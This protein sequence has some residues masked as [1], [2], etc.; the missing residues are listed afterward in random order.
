VAGLPVSTAGDYFAGRHLPSQSQP[1][2][3]TRILKACGESDAAQVDRWS[4]ALRRARRAPGPRRADAAIPYRGLASFQ[5]ED[6]AWFFGRNDLT[7]LLQDMVTGAD[8]ATVPLVV[9]GPSG[10]G[11]SSLL[12]AGLIPALCQSGLLGQ[13]S[14]N[15]RWALFT[16]GSTPV[17][18]LAAHLP[19]TAKDM[20]IA[21]ALRSAALRITELD[22]R[23]VPQLIVV[24]QFEEVF[25]ACPDEN[26][27]QAFIGA[28]AT[29]SAS[30]VVVLGLR[31]DFYGHALRYPAL[32]AALQ[33]RQ[34]VVRP[35]TKEQLT[36]AIV[37]PARLAKADVDPGLVELLLRELMPSAAKRGGSAVGHEPG[38]LPLLSHALLSTWECCR[39][40]KLTVADYQ[41]SG[42]IRGAVTRTAEAAYDALGKE[43]RDQ[44]RRLFLQLVQV[45]D[46]AA[47]TRR[48]VSVNDLLGLPDRAFGDAVANVLKGFVE[49]RLITVSEE[50]AEISHEAL[51]DAWPRLR[52]WIDE[53][54]VGLRIRRRIDDGARVWQDTGQDEAALPRGGQLAIIAEWAADLVNRASLGTLARE[55]IDA[56]SRHELAG[57]EAERRRNRRLRQLVATLAALVLVTVGLT[58]Y[59]FA[60]R[61]VASTARDNADSRELAIEASQLR[62]QDVS[63][64][65]Q[66]SL[67]AY[68]TAPTPEALAS[69]LDS[70]A[71]P[72]AARLID[73][74]DAVE[75]V[76]AS[77]DRHVLA[78]A[79]AD[80]SLRLWDIAAPGQPRALGPALIRP[81][82]SALYTA[83][84]SPDGRLLA[85]GGAGQTI[86]LW[87]V[88][89]LR[90]PVPA[91]APLSGPA[92]TVYS[93]AFTSDSRTL[94][95]GSANGTVHLWDVT[96]PS[97][98]RLL[99]KLAVPGGD[100]QT[101]AFSPDA[102]TL[103][104]GSTNGTVSLWD[105]T[106]PAHP[107]PLGK[108]LT[109]PSGAVMSIAFSPDSRTLAA[110]SRDDRV[111]L[112]NIASRADPDRL[113]PLSGATDWVNS[114][115]FSPA[116]ADLA[117]GSSDGTV[118]IWD[119]ATRSPLTVLPHPGIVTSLTWDD[120]HL[121]LTGDAD[122]VVRLWALPSP[123]L[124]ADGG[125]NAAGGG[126][127][128]VAFSPDGT[129]LAAGSQDLELWNTASRTR[130]SAV[131]VLGSWVNAVGFGQRDVLA[132]GY[133]NGTVQ[134]WRVAHGD[135]QPFGH[136]L[137]AT[138]T[139]VAVSNAMD[140]VESLAFSHDGQMLAT[141][142]DDG[143]VRL[144]DVRD[145][146]R[147]VLLAKLHDSRSW[148]LGVAFS[149]V[150][151]VLAAA[152]ADHL[153][154]LWNISKPAKPVRL[155][156]PLAGP[157]NA[158][159]SVA[160]SPDGQILAVGSADQAVRLWNVTRPAAPAL[161][162]RP[163]TGLGGY[164]YSVAFS[165]DGQ[166]LAAGI[167]DGTA[168]MWNITSP[169]HPALTA[170]LNG[171]GEA[172]FTV[173]FNPDGQT[174]AAGSKDNTIRL[175]DTRP[176]PAAS[177][178][179]A[180]SGQPLTKAEWAEYAPGRPFT[181][182][183]S[184]P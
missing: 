61:R 170:T 143:T 77:P 121:L 72:A 31:A 113:A 165:P 184:R 17:E 89:D 66:L 26:E 69:L 137:G 119:L 45:T 74:E 169:S 131:G 151:P 183:C 96:S 161:I 164:A 163:L 175:W 168:W 39:G 40:G 104:A 117:A 41:A 5:P 138:S 78:V 112:W 103:G 38:A 71:T 8:E 51:L 139:G 47:E 102:N 176:G 88:S 25:T 79:A 57:K 43:E 124:A 158:A 105:V 95:A 133:G 100:I 180:T 174:L 16:P 149:P 155:G 18:A 80:G 147:P 56:A 76:A 177:A 27:R 63:V 28:L 29:L 11:K 153:T 37:E 156:R 110:G 19:A 32:A 116:G 24:D 145:P 132:A 111:W 23:A 179:C 52:A 128:S 97:H 136:P 62:G 9:V 60:Q 173:A 73:S 86:R 171:P 134:L 140:P 13:E 99:G 167:T 123:V 135:L 65:A 182:P 44:A 12:R 3:L 108:P 75:A 154:R 81:A 159:Y 91:Q 98:P 2:L 115:A 10:S 87:N 141:G 107:V 83:A 166:T 70:T 35:M 150:G 64:A 59:A 68:R 172:V 160:F 50:T 21:A 90:H 178:I 148:V 7:Q 109:G 14:G 49:H 22:R 85:V 122:G 93:V 82:G 54:R 152:S 118:R 53:D 127:N 30:A 20:D 130:T 48:R 6:A 34:V 106:R 181:P 157:A 1:D 4:A 129:T 146:A 92:S 114:V 126:V 36:C 33:H 120:P 15:V 125:V 101:V 162:G 42:G 55:F 58:G 142:V 144:W 67:A 94:A 84:F 46:D